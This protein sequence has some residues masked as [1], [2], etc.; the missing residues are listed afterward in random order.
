MKSS[1]EREALGAP[2]S[3][4]ALGKAVRFDLVQW[5]PRQ[6]FNQGYE[7]DAKDIEFGMPF[8]QS[9]LLI[10]VVFELAGQ[11]SGC[12]LR[13]HPVFTDPNSLGP[14]TVRGFVS[15]LGSKGGER[16]ESSKSAGG[17]RTYRI[18]R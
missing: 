5:G 2:G 15:I 7:L 11:T 12:Q 8:P 3:G 17:E 18:A 14:S 1:I 4:I 10:G 16:I 6:H 13:A 9:L